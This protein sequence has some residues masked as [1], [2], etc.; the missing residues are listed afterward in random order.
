MTRPSWGWR[1]AANAAVVCAVIAMA[2]RPLPGFD[3]WWHLASGRE[4]AR[5]CRIPRADPFSFT[6]RGAPWMDHE[7]LWQLGAY[8]VF[9]AAAGN[10]GTAPADAGQ[11]AIERRDRQEAIGTSAL[12]LATGAALSVAFLLGTLALRARGTGI[13]AASL[14]ALFC[15][16]GARIRFLVR[17]ES[18]TIL[19][20]AAVLFIM[21]RSRRTGSGRSL[22]AIPPLIV[23]CANLHAGALIMPFLVVAFVAGDRISAR[24]EM[25]GP[26]GGADGHLPVTWSGA[27]GLV[28][29][30]FIATLVN[31]WTWRLWRAPLALA[32]ITRSANYYN[33]EWLP[34]SAA[35]VPLLYAGF[36]I[37]AF[38][39]LVSLLRRRN[40]LASP[41][42]APPACGPFPDPDLAALL[43]ALGLV[44]M[45]VGAVRHVGLFF[46]VLPFAV[47]GPLATLMAARARQGAV[48]ARVGAA[49]AIGAAGLVVAGLCL[50]GRARL[51]SDPATTPVDACRFIAL[52]Q[53]SGN[54]FNDVRFGG[55]L[56]WR[57][58]PARGVFIDGRN[59]LFT[60]LMKE[61]EGVYSGRSGYDVWQDL[62]RRHGIEGAL[63]RYMEGKKGVIYPPTDGQ[64]ARKD[65]RAFSAYLFPSAVW[66]LVHWD[67]TAMIFLRRDG[68]NR[69]MAAS[70]AYEAVNPEDWEHLL[71]RAGEDPSLRSALERDLARREGEAPPSRRA[72]RMRAALGSLPR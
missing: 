8:G 64:P 14:M 33:P 36:A 50:A 17:P 62:L 63:V 32:G 12:T 30:A 58:G 57:F 53:P 3:T 52:H 71:S 13:L 66:A 51:G 49:V 68:P 40:L 65:H 29:S 43:P 47:A 72:A 61:L 19:C 28:A 25:G 42:A 39:L 5:T 70:L 27:A 16:W 56:A 11:Q 37:L 7:W 2:V 44:A 26:R 48:R 55:Y 22:L 9:R 38:A 18:A 41:G 6:S 4:M 31:P 45:T 34:P 24:L 15:A 59:E 69:S 21:D 46:V 1:F 20:A 60:G 54:L 10:D 35:T 23:I 67:D